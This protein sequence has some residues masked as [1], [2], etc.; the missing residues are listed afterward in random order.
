M[1]L[2]IHRA[3]QHSVETCT[4][5]PKLCHWACPMM[6]AEA[7]ESLS[8]WGRMNL[9]D[10]IKRGRALPNRESAALLERCCLCGRCEQLCLHQIPIPKISRALRGV[11]HSLGLH[12]PAL[13]IWARQSPK[14]SALFQ[15]LPQGQ[16]L[17]LIP[18]FADQAALEAALKLLE[19]VDLQPGRSSILHGGHRLRDLGLEE[20]FQ[21][22]RAQVQAQPGEFV[23][24]EPGDL[25][26]LKPYLGARVRHLSELLN[27]LPL[28]PVEGQVLYL[29]DPRLGRGL[30]LYDPPRQLLLGAVEEIKE[31]LL[32]RAEG[33]ALGIEGGYHILA[34]EA[35][36]EIARGRVQSELPVVVVGA[37]GA[38]HLRRALPQQK[39]YDWS[40]LLASALER[41]A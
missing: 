11:A 14:P 8:P 7:R 13:S 22:H 21:L 32:S 38:A 15:R 18:G 27:T 1:F 36:L 25:E 35:A 26:A 33:G 34:P 24:L 19:A 6:G 41:S 29:D 12:S 31:P 2:E 5:C 30:G 17:S 16:P 10:D 39:I 28:R 20:E 37:E 4:F 40:V 23:C 9:L 3:H